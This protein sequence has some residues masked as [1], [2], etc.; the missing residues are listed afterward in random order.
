MSIVRS[1]WKEGMEHGE[2]S[3]ARC[4]VLKAKGADS[5]CKMMHFTRVCVAGG[6]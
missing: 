1:H 5:T 4:S 2:H 3:C 6:K